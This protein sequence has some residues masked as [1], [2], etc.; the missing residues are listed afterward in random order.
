MLR[1]YDTASLDMA[2]VRA[3]SLRAPRM[4]EVALEAYC[5]ARSRKNGWRHPGPG[6]GTKRGKKKARGK[7]HSRGQRSAKEQGKSGGTYRHKKTEGTTRPSSSGR[8]KDSVR[9]GWGAIIERFGME[10]VPLFLCGRRHAVPSR[11]NIPLL[12]GPP[13]DI[14]CFGKT[15]QE[16]NVI[17]PPHVSRQALLSLC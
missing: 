13:R 10:M 6:P 4:T 14:D 2:A 17:V 9:R 3:G 5:S 8:G 12:P 15:V 11:H 1:L 16:P 7:R